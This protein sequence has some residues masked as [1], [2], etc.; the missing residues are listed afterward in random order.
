[1][2]D[3]LRIAVLGVFAATGATLGILVALELNDHSSIKPSLETAGMPADIPWDLPDA[4]GQDE[5][6]PPPLGEAAP[7][8]SY[9]VADSA[10]TAPPA[11]TEAWD[12]VSRSE[13]APSAAWSD[14]DVAT[15]A[16]FAGDADPAVWQA[17][18]EPNPAIASIDTNPSDATDF[19]SGAYLP[20]PAWESESAATGHAELEADTNRCS[21]AAPTTDESGGA[22]AATD[23]PP[24]G[25][26]DDRDCGS[27]PEPH[28]TPSPPAPSKASSPTAQ[29]TVVVRDSETDAPIA[30]IRMEGEVCQDVA[31]RIVQI[32]VPVAAKADVQ[33]VSYQADMSAAQPQAPVKAAEPQSLPSPAR[34]PARAEQSSQQRTASPVARQAVDATATTP[35]VTR[36]KTSLAVASTPRTPTPEEVIV[37]AGDSV[38]D[39]AAALIE[40]DQVPLALELLQVAAPI[41]GHQAL[42]HE[43]MGEALLRTGEVTTAHR[44]LE[45]SLHLDKRSARANYLMGLILLQQGQQ[46]RGEHYLMQA[47]DLDPRYA[48]RPSQN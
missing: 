30:S 42:Y 6:L 23:A 45:K 39:Q 19:T 4:S 26:T 22:A 8:E 32:P 13:A 27:V 5:V 37:N 34:T 9:A 44:A 14:P 2:K 18:A 24:C 40:A 46:N 3:T 7:L 10:S 35:S 48:I 12:A 47:H 43:L 36:S 21:T 29:Q 15:P 31:V 1:M 33:R 11:R 16:G 25:T 28:P 20:P 41:Y 38:L 17:S